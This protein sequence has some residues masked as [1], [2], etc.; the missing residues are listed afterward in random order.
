MQIFRTL[1]LAKDYYRVSK[2]LFL[3]VVPKVSFLRSCVAVMKVR[4]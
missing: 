4:K 2:S 3:S 1:E